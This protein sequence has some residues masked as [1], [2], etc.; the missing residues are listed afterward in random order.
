MRSLS[1]VPHINLVGALTMS[2]GGKGGGFGLGRL[3][4]E[5]FFATPPKEEKRKERERVCATFNWEEERGA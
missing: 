4:G 5:I 2:A 3:Y 1:P